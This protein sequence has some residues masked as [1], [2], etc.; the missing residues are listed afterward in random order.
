VCW[1]SYGIA[2]DDWWIAAPNLF[3]SMLSL[4][5]LCMIIVFPSSEQ[6]Q[7]LTPTSSAEGL[8]DLDT[9]TTV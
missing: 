1:T 9:S 7:R 6:I 5:Q 3:G 8:V 4:V 2:L